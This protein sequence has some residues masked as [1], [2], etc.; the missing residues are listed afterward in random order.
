MKKLIKNLPHEVIPLFNSGVAVLIQSIDDFNQLLKLNE[1]EE[2]ENDCLGCVIVI[3]NEEYRIYA[4]G[5]FNDSLTTLVHELTH[6]SFY[7][8]RDTAM[9]FDTDYTNEPFAY[10]TD[11]YF[12]LW[13][14]YF[15]NR[16]D[17]KTFLDEFKK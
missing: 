13:E 10:L 16:C 14:Q 1:L 17:V 5:V 9:S 15:T 11:H 3:E 4:V 2:I 8:Y 7:V 12:Q 6:L